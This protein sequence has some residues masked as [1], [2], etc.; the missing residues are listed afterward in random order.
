[1]GL[2]L[3]E[4]PDEPDSDMHNNTDIFRIYQYKLLVLMQTSGVLLRLD[5]KIFQLGDLH[6]VF[7]YERQIENLGNFQGRFMLKVDCKEG[8]SVRSEGAVVTFED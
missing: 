7:F 3:G 8:M 4:Q 6:N 1:M 5:P 2:S